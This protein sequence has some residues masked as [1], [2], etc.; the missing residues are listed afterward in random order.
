MENSS[1]QPDNDIKNETEDVSAEFKEKLEACD[2][3]IKSVVSAQKKEI[4]KLLE[5]IGKYQVELDSLRREVKILKKNQGGSGILHLD[6]DLGD[7]ME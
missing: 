1:P 6:M 5:R 4:H 3:E 7:G 2:P